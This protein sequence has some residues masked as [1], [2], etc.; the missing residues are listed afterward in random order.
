MTIL[1][2]RWC[3]DIYT[4]EHNFTYQKDH[5][6]KNRE[7]VFTFKSYKVQNSFHFDEIFHRKFKI[8]ILVYGALRRHLVAI[9]GIFAVLKLIFPYRNSYCFLCSDQQSHSS[10]GR[11]AYNSLGH[12]HLSRLRQVRFE[13]TWTLLLFAHHCHGGDF[14]LRVYCRRSQS[15]Q[16][17]WRS[18]CTVVWKLRK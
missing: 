1:Y 10:L 3:F 2:T 18:G 15:S 16:C 14:W 5:G 8:P 7:T 9:L 12:V 11:R 13:K 17:G 4:Q 6:K